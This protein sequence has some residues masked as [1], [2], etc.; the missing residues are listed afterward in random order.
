M[1][2][3]K[4]IPAEAAQKYEIVVVSPRNYFLYTPLLPAVCT[5]TMED[6]S[7]VEPVRNQMIGKGVYYEAICQ[8]IDPDAKELVCCFPKDAGL[9]QACFKINY[10][11]L[12][13]AVGSINNTFGT[14]GV[15]DNCYFFKTIDDAKRLRQRV[16]ELFERAALPYVPEEERRKLLSLVVVGG[17]PTGV[18]VAAEMRDMIKEDMEKL[19]PSLKGLSKVSVIELQDHIL[20]TYDRRISQYAAKQFY[21]DDI[22]LLLGTKVAGVERDFVKLVK[23]DV[24]SELKFGVCVWCTGIRLNPL[25]Q[26]LQVALPEGSQTNFRAINTDQYL[27]VKGSNGSIFAIGDSATIEQ[28]RALQVCDELFEKVSAVGGSRACPS[29]TRNALQP[30]LGPCQWL[31]RQG[32]ADMETRLAASALRARGSPRGSCPAPAAEGTPP[33]ARGLAP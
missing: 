28:P 4:A 5:G 26:Q 14:P 1:S 25:A 8:S 16:S 21:R 18:E 6:R 12:I 20:S 33:P 32:S 19:Y 10:D 11:I 9:D 27:R 13:T 15:E 23:D 31:S 24:P 22:N 30:S 7:I 17:G 29:W 3:I 2:L